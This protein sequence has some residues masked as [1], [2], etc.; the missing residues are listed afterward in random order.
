MN[1]LERASAIGIE[2]LMHCEEAERLCDLACNR[3]V[4]EVGSYKGFSSWVM[5][6][7]AK[8]VTACDTFAAATDGQRQTG[9]TTT[10]DD[11]LRATARFTHVL[12]YQMTSEEAGRALDSQT[13]D[14]IFIDADHSYESVRDDIQRWWP[15]LRSGGVFCGHD[16]GHSAYPGV[17]QAF[18]EAFGP[19]PEGTTLITL[20]WIE[21]T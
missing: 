6:I 1:L 13:Y 16:Y 21:K 12:H 2:N 4:L 5:A 20:R 17:Q 10:L 11:F 8:S 9:E 7:T 14:L 3:D 15:K 19:A 18:D